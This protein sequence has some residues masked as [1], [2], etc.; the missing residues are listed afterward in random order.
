MFPRT[1]FLSFWPQR[2]ERR[3]T[4]ETRLSCDLQQ[5]KSCHVYTHVVSCSVSILCCFGW[6]C[7]VS[8]LIKDWI[9]YFSSLLLFSQMPK[10]FSQMHLQKP[11]LNHLKDVLK[12]SMS[13][14]LSFSLF[15][16]LII[17]V[18]C[19]TYIKLFLPWFVIDSILLSKWSASIKPPFSSY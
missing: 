13:T 14:T 1:M 11:V 18:C 6:V 9:V 16:L 5:I 4:I 17:S 12:N 7:T 2:V 19:K 15:L 8:F 3:Q 10:L